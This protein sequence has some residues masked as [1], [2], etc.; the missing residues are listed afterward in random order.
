MP[1]F[2][3]EINERKY[4][5]PWTPMLVFSPVEKNAL[6]LGTQYVMKTTDGGLHWEKISPDLTGA[7]PNA[8]AKSPPDPPRWRTRRS[9]ALAW[10]S[11]SRPR[12]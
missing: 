3:S 12:R 10:C 6:Y 7:A 8:P 4:R 9:A 1:N 11:A 5:D 2:G